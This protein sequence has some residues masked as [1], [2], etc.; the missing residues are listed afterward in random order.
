MSSRDIEL[1]KVAEITVSE[2]ADLFG[3]SRQAVYAGVNKPQHYLNSGHLLT[4]IQHAKRNDSERL[5]AIIGFVASRYSDSETETDKDL[6]LPSRNGLQQLI[7][8]CTVRG[9]S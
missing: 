2:A 6:V 8:A 4:I 7:S 5:Q 1:L 9:E 3:R